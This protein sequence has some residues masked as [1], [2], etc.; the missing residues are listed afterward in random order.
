MIDPGAKIAS[1]EP[2]GQPLGRWLPVPRERARFRVLSFSLVETSVG[3]LKL[4]DRLSRNGLPAPFD[5][6]LGGE[7]VE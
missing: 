1:Y 2:G 6:V 5:L 7:G 3:E 4:I